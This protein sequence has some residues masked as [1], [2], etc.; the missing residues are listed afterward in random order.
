MKSASY[1]IFNCKLIRTKN[2]KKKLDN[3]KI[4]KINYI[5]YW[6]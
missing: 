1:R 2:S 4:I 5:V 3:R 6:Y